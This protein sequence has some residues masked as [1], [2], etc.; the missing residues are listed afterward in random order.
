MDWVPVPLCTGSG[1]DELTF[2]IVACIVLHSEFVTVTVLITQPRFGCA[3][4]AWRMPL[5]CTGFPWGVDWGCARCWLSHLTP[6]DTVL[7]SKSLGKG[8]MFVVMCVLRPHFPGGHWTPASWWKGVAKLLCF[9]C[10]ESITL[11][12]Y[13]LDLFYLLQEFPQFCTSCSLPPPCLAKEG[14]SEQL[15]GWLAGWGQPAAL[16]NAHGWTWP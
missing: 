3:R 12:I 6:S 13:L 15:W 8:R 7:S 9:A 10:A 14:A 1:W 4:A 2:F 16:W 5:S 11:P